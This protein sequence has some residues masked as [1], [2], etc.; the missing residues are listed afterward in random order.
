MNQLW[1]LRALKAHFLCL[2]RLNPDNHDT[3]CTYPRATAVSNNTETRLIIN[4]CEIIK[5]ADV[6]GQENT[7][8][9]FFAY[10][11]R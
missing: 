9:E 7:Q 3:E 11:W 4:K 1:S 8:I 5:T 2:L 10:F 6:K